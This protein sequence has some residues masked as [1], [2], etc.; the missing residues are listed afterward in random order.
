MK[1][2]VGTACL[3]MSTR[4]PLK[5]MSLFVGKRPSRLA[6]V[7]ARPQLEGKRSWGDL[8]IHTNGLRYVSHGRMDQ[9]IGMPLLETVF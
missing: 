8:E 7:Y 2:K 9:K 6:E 3:G 5:D 4:V 1:L